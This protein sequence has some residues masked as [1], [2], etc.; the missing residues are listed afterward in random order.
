[1]FVWNYEKFEKRLADMESWYQ[2][3][4]KD[5]SSV[6]HYDYDPWF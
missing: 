6:E 1:M 4:G 2:G 3:A 5:N